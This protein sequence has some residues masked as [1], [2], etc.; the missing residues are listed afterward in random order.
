MA[1]VR[2]LASGNVRIIL[3]PNEA[4]KAGLV[5]GLTTA[6]PATPARPKVKT[7]AEMKAGL[8]YPCA[9]GCKAQTRTWDRAQIH[10]TPATL[11]AAGH[12]E[13]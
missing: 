9:L 12:I 1:R 6:A 10:A 4:A 8:G 2:T 7:R 5:M 3:T 13:R 11:Q